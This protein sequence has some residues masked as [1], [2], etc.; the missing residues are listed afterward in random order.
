MAVTGVAVSPPRPV[1]GSTVAASSE[2]AC[3]GGDRAASVLS[4]RPGP[5]A[6][7][8]RLGQSV[9]RPRRR[10]SPAV[11]VGP[12]ATTSRAPAIATGTTGQCGRGNDEGPER[13]RRKP[14]V[15]CNEPSGRTPGALGQ[16]A[17]RAARR[18]PCSKQRARGPPTNTQPR[19]RRNGPAIRALSAEGRTGGEDDRGLRSPRSARVRRQSSHGWRR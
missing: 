17:P 10:H 18:G 4:Q 7:D 3:G 8:R 9:A 2:R 13:K 16:R 11:R 12:A 6:C 19:R 5:L 15:G 1:G 14:G